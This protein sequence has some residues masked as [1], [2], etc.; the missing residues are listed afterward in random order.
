MK[1]AVLRFFEDDRHVTLD[2][3]R[4]RLPDQHCIEIS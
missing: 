4:E 1:N 2:E 3:I